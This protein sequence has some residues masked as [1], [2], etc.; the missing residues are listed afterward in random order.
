M[1]GKAQRVALPAPQTRL[2]NS[3]VTGPRSPNFNRCTW[4]INGVNTRI[5]V[6]NLPSI[7]EFQCTEQRWGM[8][9]SANRHQKSVTI[10]TSLEQSQNEGQTDH[11]H[12]HAY[13]R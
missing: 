9:I 2:Q 13:L 12:P 8:P 11:A 3:G 5:Y 6:A 1:H 7:V 4:V 10:A